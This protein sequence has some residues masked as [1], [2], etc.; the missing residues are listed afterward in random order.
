M[1]AMAI[2]RWLMIKARS[3]MTG[4]KMGGHLVPNHM[5]ASIIQR[6]KREHGL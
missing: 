3:P 6:Y 2:K 4:N 1:Q 5:V